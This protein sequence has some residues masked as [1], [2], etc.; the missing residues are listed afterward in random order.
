MIGIIH[1]T[2]QE[3][4]FG[5]A[6]IFTVAKTTKGQ[7]ALG[8]STVE[9]QA[10]VEDQLTVES[11]PRGLNYYH[12]GAYFTVEQAIALRDAL[13]LILTKGQVA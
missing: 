7:V 2:K 3:R 10:G 6:M 8:I 11:I 13:T 12:R 5:A 9:T 1:S 4:Q